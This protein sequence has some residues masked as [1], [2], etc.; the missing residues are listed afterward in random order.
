MGIK[1]VRSNN[2]SG[3]RD[4]QAVEDV[5]S[6]QPAVEEKVAEVADVKAKESVINLSECAPVEFATV[7]SDSGTANKPVMSRVVEEAP[8]VGAIKE[9]FA[10]PE[11]TRKSHPSA[12]GVSYVKLTSEPA[13]AEV[14]LLGSDIK[15]IE[16]V[17]EVPAGEPVLDGVEI[18]GDLPAEVEAQLE[19]VVASKEPVEEKSMAVEDVVSDEPEVDEAKAAQV[20]SGASKEDIEIAWDK[21]V[22]CVIVPTIN[23]C[24]DR[25]K[26]YVSTELAA[27]LKKV[28]PDI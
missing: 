7:V 22:D 14:K 5:K 26:E 3:V 9:R 11:F 28:N 12:A 15:S 4:G 25:A 27:D 19:S 10:I 13:K 16:L 2:F 18:E 23:T 8:E 6:E 21:F 1:F 17:S 24:L 20:D